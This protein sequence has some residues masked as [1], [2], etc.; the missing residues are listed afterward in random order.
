MHSTALFTMVNVLLTVNALW[1]SVDVV[2]R[3]ELNAFMRSTILVHKTVQHAQE[4]TISVCLSY[5]NYSDS[6]LPSDFFVHLV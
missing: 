5:G 2:Q 3:N 6:C 4:S 1:G